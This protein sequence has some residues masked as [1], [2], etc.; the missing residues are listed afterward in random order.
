[1]ST[2]EANNQVQSVW[3]RHI[4]TA[5]AVRRTKRLRHT[6]MLESPWIIFYLVCTTHRFD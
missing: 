5:V 6:G 3:L 1:M 2:E 4:Y